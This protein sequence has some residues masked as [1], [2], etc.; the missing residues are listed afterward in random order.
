MEKVK[1]NDIE[2]VKFISN[3]SFNE[4]GSYLAYV[5]SEASIEE[6]KYTSNI[7]LYEVKSNKHWK[8]TS[9]DKEGSFQWLDNEHII[10]NGIRDDKDKERKK[11]KEEFTTVYKIYIHG[12]EAVK[13]FELPVN[14]SQYKIVDEETVLVRYTTNLNSKDLFSLDDKDKKEELKRRKDEEDYAVL[15]EIPYWSN[16]TSEFTSMNRERLAHFNIKTGKLKVLTKGITD[17]GNIILSKDKSKALYTLNSIKGKV[18][19]F[20]KLYL[21]DT[22]TFKSEELKFGKKAL[23]GYD[24]LNEDTLVLRINNR[25]KHGLNQNALLYTFDLKKKELNVI[26]EDLDITIGSSVGSDMRHGGGSTMIVKNDF[27]YYV[28]TNDSDSVLKKMD[29]KGNITTLCDE[30]GSTDSFSVDANENIIAVQMKKDS[31]QELYSISDKK[32]EVISSYNKEYLDTHSI[33]KAEPLFVKGEGDDIIKGFVLKPTNYKK[34][35]KYPAILDIHGGPKTVYSSVFYHEM[36]VWANMGYF[37]FFCNPKGSDGKG[38]EFMDIR[39]RYGEIDYENIMDFTDMVLDKYKDIDKDRVGVTGGSY[40]GFM[41][42]WIIGHTDRFKCAAS[43]RS[44]SNWISMYATTDIGYYFA[45]DQTGAELWQNQEKMWYHS[46]LKYAD[47]V[48]TPTLFI[49][50]DQDYRCWMAEGL[51]MFTAL[52]IHG[53]EARLCL[54]HGENHELSRSGKPKHR[55]RRLTEITNWFE[56]HLK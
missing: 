44:I 18:E 19:L 45:N 7:Y 37:V 12:G 24:F 9:Q 13:F 30:E 50:S 35:K 42:N 15:E 16:G 47:K 48:K 28:E 54:F 52:K 27:I 36:Q 38:N 55:V 22:K 23:Y 26:K 32:A 56:S 53:V 5:L 21:M 43:Q 4:D 31:L 41:T 33:S 14:A 20:D 10:F 6:N 51:Q 2:K 34:G 25:D 29:I 3:P 17:A 1:I 40:G 8:L 11:N 46:P 49:H 39:G